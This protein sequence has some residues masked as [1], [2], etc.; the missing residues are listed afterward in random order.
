M[1]DLALRMTKPRAQ[2][3]NVTVAVQPP[4]PQLTLN[5]D[6]T[7]L[8][9][10]WI[11]LI[12][13]AVDAAATGGR[14]V[15]VSID[16]Q[17]GFAVLRVE[18]DGPGLDPEIADKLFEPFVTTKPLGSGTGLGLSVAKRIVEGHQGHI[19]IYPRRSGG[20]CAEIHIPAGVSPTI[21]LPSTPKSL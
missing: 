10:A 19:E 11:N 16:E 2:R 9:Q 21:G 6:L 18:D 1:L 13:N 4:S 8:A 17:P 3:K 7:R 5:A 15:T 12:S 20:T 14:H